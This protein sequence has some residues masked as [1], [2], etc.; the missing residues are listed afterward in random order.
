M[1]TVGSFLDQNLLLTRLNLINL[2]K[3]P[4]FYVKPK[5]NQSNNIQGGSGE[6]VTKHTFFFEFQIKI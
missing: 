6:R 2:D 1:F 4:Y 5:P 3:N